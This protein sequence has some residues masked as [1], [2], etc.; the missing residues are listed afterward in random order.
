ML[1]MGECV[2]AYLTVATVPPFTAHSRLLLLGTAP[3]LSPTIVR[4]PS[5]RWYYSD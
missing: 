1:T 3:V 5:R 2:S 4:L